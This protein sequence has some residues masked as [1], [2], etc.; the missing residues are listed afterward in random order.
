MAALT[1]QLLR[2]RLV[3]PNGVTLEKSGTTDDPEVIRLLREQARI[4]DPMGLPRYVRLT[5]GGTAAKA[6]PT[7]PAP[8]AEPTPPPAAPTPPA[9]PTPPAPDALKLPEGVTEKEVER[10]AGHLKDAG[11]TFQTANALS[12]ADLLPLKQIGEAAVKLIRA[13]GEANGYPAFSGGDEP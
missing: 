1:Y 10:L 12:D 5:E 11:H 4:K 9:E 13:V 6:E 8:P 2:G 3:L 7:P